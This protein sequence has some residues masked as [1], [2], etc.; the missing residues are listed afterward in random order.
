MQFKVPI[1]FE[2][3]TNIFNNLLK[4]WWLL[5]LLGSCNFKANHLKIKTRFV[6][7][8]S[9]FETSSRTSNLILVWWRMSRLKTAQCCSMQHRRKTT[10][11]HLACARVRAYIYCLTLK[12][13]DRLVKIGFISLSSKIGYNVGHPTVLVIN[14]TT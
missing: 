5:W 14:T 6:L 4:K 1:I 2:L 9:F 7:T 8:F 12:T 3:L 10:V 13:F 11:M